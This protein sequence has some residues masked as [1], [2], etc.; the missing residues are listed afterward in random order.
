MEW[1]LLRR[2]LLPCVAA[3]FLFPCSSNGAD[4]SVS[5]GA[6]AVSSEYRETSAH[7]YAMPLVSVETESFYIKGLG[8]G[9]YLWKGEGHKLSLGL[10]YLPVHFRPNDSSSHAMKQLDKRYTSLLASA[11]WEYSSKDRGQ[12]RLKIAADILGKNEG[13]LADMSYSLPLRFGDVTLT[14]T[15]GVL[16]AS[17]EYNDYYYGIGASES[18]RSGLSAYDAGDA[19]FP[20]ASMRFDVALNA[21]WGLY[22]IASAMVLDDEVCDSPM[23]DERM[24][25]GICGGVRYTF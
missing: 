13:F 1:F 11:E 16:W 8:A 22:A 7:V 17:E 20:Y 25:Y 14:P 23:V 5:A 19:L 21:N 15:V 6:M 2:Y 9:A 18:K 12:L 4:I 3:L 10:E 24:K